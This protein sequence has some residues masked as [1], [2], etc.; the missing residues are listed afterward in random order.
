MEKLGQD[1][2]YSQFLGQN[3]IVRTYKGD[4]LINEYKPLYIP[5]AD[6]SDIRVDCPE[7]SIALYAGHT[8]ITGG[9]LPYI[10]VGDPTIT[11]ST[12]TSSDSNYLI[13]KDCPKYCTF[14]AKITTGADVNSWQYV[15]SSEKLFDVTIENGY[16]RCYRFDIAEN[17]QLCA[18]S[19]N[20]PYYIKADSYFD[21]EYSVKLYSVS[22]NGT[23]WTYGT[24]NFVDNAPNDV[25]DVYVGRH[26]SVDGYYFKGSFDLST[27]YV[28]NTDDS[29]F[30]APYVAQT[31]QYDNLGFTAN[32]V[33]G[34]NVFI[35]GTQYGST[36]ASGS[37]CTIT[38]ST[39]GITTGDDITTPSALKAHKIWISPATSGNNITRFASVRVSTGSENEFQGKLWIHFNLSN[40]IQVS[41]LLRA[42]GTYSINN[43]CKAI[44]AK[45]NILNCY[46]RISSMCQ[47]GKSLEYLP[48]L[49]STGIADNCQGAFN[50]CELLKYITLKNFKFSTIN[51]GFNN[52]YSLEKIKHS[53]TEILNS[54][55]S[56]INS[57]YNECRK[58]QNLLPE[59]YTANIS[60]AQNYIHNT[61]ELKDTV[62]DLRGATALT[63]LGIF[64]N[65]TYF[66]KGIKGVR[67]SNE[68]PFNRN[69]TPQIN[70]SYTG[71]DRNA[72][73]QLFNDLPYNVGYEVVGSPT[74]NN[75]VVSNFSD[76]DNL[77]LSQA[78]VKEGNLEMKFEFTTGADINTGQYLFSWQSNPSGTNR[79]CGIYISNGRYG[80]VMR[81]IDNTN[82][83]YANS[84]GA[85]VQ[86]NT[87]YYL[88]TIFNTEDKSLKVGLSTDDASYTY[89]I[90]YTLSNN[91][92]LFNSTQYLPQIG[93][94]MPNNYFW[95]G[96]I[97]LNTYIKINDVYW[98]R[99]QAAMTKTLS[100]VGATGNQNKLTIVGS[101]TI[102]NGVLGGLSAN[103]YAYTN[104]SSAVTPNIIE[105]GGSF[106][107]SAEGNGGWI[108]SNINS[109]TAWQGL[110]LTV[111]NTADANQGILLYS[112]TSKY[113]FKA[114]QFVA[115]TTY[116]YKIVYSKE[117]HSADL[118]IDNVLLGTLSNLEWDV[119]LGGEFQIGKYNTDYFKGNINLNTIYIKVDSEEFFN[120]EQYLLPEDKAIVTNKGWT[121]N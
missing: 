47:D 114:K 65:S 24:A 104:I 112:S 36:Y 21:N 96:S 40:T 58:L 56:T 69:T 91:M 19:A 44:T 5:P 115:N 70:V 53:N 1:N 6:W 94:A 15:L 80:I 17:I 23:D 113:F 28:K 117:N 16:L 4:Q 71:L 9:S 54:A 81:E 49:V 99:G 111:R 13:A 103:D 73:V 8:P 30:I 118:F 32:C 35:D 86:A 72:L 83:Q 120:R 29:Y 55:N 61:S 66:A 107:M 82:H 95:Q 105:I 41:N 31:V 67:V 10:K 39:S 85:V 12:Y 59:T 121:F 26:L 90:Q 52:C 22:L 46:Q 97:N 18:V 63:E 7:N 14:V 37:N 87:H 11:E 51:Y 93:R 106:T 3:P 79:Q 25:N 119:K 101:P 92:C 98:F 20:T 88:K 110:A 62:I 27:T 102:N 84:G 45:N 109:S 50:G 108:F 100:C 89:G 78:S 43:I 64:S 77:K 38:W 116:N 34:Y 2:I 60:R 68:A 57:Q 76:T 75:D 42:S 74:I 33:G 48:V